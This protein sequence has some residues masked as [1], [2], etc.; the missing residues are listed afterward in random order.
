MAAKTR[1]QIET[2]SRDAAAWYPLGDGRIV[3]RVLGSTKIVVEQDD[4]SLAPHLVMDG[5]WES[6][7]TVWCLANT[8]PSDRVLNIGA[9]CGYFSLLFARIAS[10]V[11]AVEPQPRLAA[12][13]RRSAMLNGLANLAVEEV[14]AGVEER[15]VFLKL[16]DGLSGSAHVTETAHGTELRVRER[17]SGDLLPDATCVFVDAEG[18]EPL[19]WAGLGPALPSARWVCL[20][21]APDR[22]KDAVGFLAALRA[23]GSIT[24]IATD[25]SEAQTSD[26][27]L[28][29]SA[30]GSLE[31]IVVRRHA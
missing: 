3:A 23:W 31:T 29:S 1:A 10:K 9:N 14:V 25:G 12:N 26:A 8:R 5:F 16:Y 11:V 15:D 18:Y 19:I 13:I 21:W 4:F 20:E 30:T 22:Y 6:W 2:I 7:V 17:P 28:L 27:A 24:V